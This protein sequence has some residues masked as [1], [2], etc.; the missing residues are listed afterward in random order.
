MLYVTFY[1]IDTLSLYI[2]KDFLLRRK[3]ALKRQTK[4][5]PRTSK[6]KYRHRPHVETSEDETLT[7]A[8]KRAKRRRKVPTAEKIRKKY[9]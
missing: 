2:K 9:F 4:K 3:F 8:Q 5:K 7:E 1:A 6:R